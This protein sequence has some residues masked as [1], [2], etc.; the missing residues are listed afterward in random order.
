M[1]QFVTN[2]IMFICLNKEQLY[3][4][5][6]RRNSY[7][8]NFHRKSFTMAVYWFSTCPVPEGVQ[9]PYPLYRIG[10]GGRCFNQSLSKGAHSCQAYRTG[11]VMMSPI[12]LYWT[13]IYINIVS[14]YCQHTRIVIFQTTQ[15]CF[16][17]LL[18][19]CSRFVYLPTLCKVWPFFMH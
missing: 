15:L 6:L 4:E 3:L 9:P 11:H 19:C 16:F 8:I 14:L 13:R 7:K 12:S 2:F 17:T 18:S 1:R 5:I 10:G